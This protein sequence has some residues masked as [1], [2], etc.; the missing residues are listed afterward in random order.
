ML[1][2]VVQGPYGLVLVGEFKDRLDESAQPEAL[3]YYGQLWDHRFQSMHN[4]S[5]AASFIVELMGCHMRLVSVKAGRKS[6]ISVC[7]SS[8]C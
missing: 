3:R 4:Q 1:V 2:S 5:F 7:V 6:G 8:I